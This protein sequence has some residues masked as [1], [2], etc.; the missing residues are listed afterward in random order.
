MIDDHKYTYQSS[1]DYEMKETNPL[2]KY[3][4]LTAEINAEDIIAYKKIQY[5]KEHLLS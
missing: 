4:F 3:E 1:V 5:N 2:T